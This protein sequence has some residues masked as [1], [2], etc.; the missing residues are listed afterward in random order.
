MREL[1]KDINFLIAGN[2]IHV[3]GVAIQIEPVLVCDMKA[4]IN[5]MGV[6]TVYHP[7][8]WW[9]CLWCHVC[10]KDIGD[11]S[12]PCWPFRNRQ[13][14]KEIIEEIKQ[15][16]EAT[17]KANGRRNG[18][19][20][21]EPVFDFDLEHIIPC[22]LHCIMAVIKKLLRLTANEAGLNLKLVNDCS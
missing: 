8:A 4:L 15:L 9:K 11:F 5:L 3:G 22:M 1:A 7:K 2:D 19:V 14:W 18:G 10:E 16:S 20:I 21:G 12:I 6:Y 13:R 17:A